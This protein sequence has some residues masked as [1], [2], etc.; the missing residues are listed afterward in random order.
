MREPAFEIGDLRAAGGDVDG[1]LGFGGFRG[2]QLALGRCQLLAQAAAFVFGGGGFL[3]Q[4]GRLAAQLAVGG[5]GI[6]EHRLQRDLV[7]ALVLD[8]LERLADRIDQPGDRVLDA[9]EFFDLGGGVEHQIAQRLVFAAELHAAGG[10][11]FF[12]EFERVVRGRRLLGGDGGWLAGE[13]APELLHGSDPPDAPIRPAEAT[14]N[15]REAF[16]LTECE[17]RKVNERLR[18]QRQAGKGV[19]VQCF[20][21]DHRLR[22]TAPFAGR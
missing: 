17:S 10:E 19:S 6:V 20:K 18:M 4:L 8:D 11:Q 1:D 13:K 14:P 7:G 5:A 16:S 9:V 22:P 3:F 12:V 21:A 15:H 2:L